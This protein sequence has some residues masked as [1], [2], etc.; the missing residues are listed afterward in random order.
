MNKSRIE[1]I[2]GIAEKWDLDALEVEDSNGAVRVVR[3]SG[4][5]VAASPATGES[6]PAAPKP[7]EQTQGVPDGTEQV[8]SSMVGIFTTQPHDADASP[9]QAGDAVEQGQPIGYLEAM[10]MVTTVEAPCAGVVQ[11]IQAADGQSVQFGQ[12]L[13]LIRRAGA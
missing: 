11:E 10:K 3:R 9:V 6:A 8:T 13:F 1:E 12:P 5:V 2:I 7:E 4:G